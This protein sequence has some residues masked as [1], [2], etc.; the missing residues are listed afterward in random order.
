MNFKVFGFHE[1]L[2]KLFATISVVSITFGCVA[3]YLLLKRYNAGKVSPE[4]F[5]ENFLI[6]FQDSSFILSVVYALF[7]FIVG[8]YLT[9]MSTKLQNLYYR[10]KEQ[11]KNLIRLNEVLSAEKVTDIS[12]DKIMS[13]IIIHQSFTGRNIEKKRKP[14]ILQDGFSYSSKFLELEES[15]LLQ[16]RTIVEIYNLKVNK[17][18]DCYGL[19]KK[20][21]NIFISDLDKFLVEVDNWIDNNLEVAETQ[22]TSFK[23]YLG[24][25][26]QA[27]SRDRRKHK[28]SKVKYKKIILKSKRKVNGLISKIESVYGARLQNDLMFEDNLTFNLF[29][30][31]NIIKA[32]DNKILTY[33]D[34]QELFSEQNSELHEV[35]N[36]IN[37]RIYELKKLFEDD[38]GF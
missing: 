22:R 8:L 20:H 5:F 18:I 9:S 17:Y 6:E 11:Y 3:Y 16:R 15:I 35:I 30:L 33:D 1:R 19:S 36:S 12:D 29:E 34:L 37:D 13:S 31:E 4:N 26:I 21:L 7:L 24:K 38:D 14:Y 10:R 27:S 2:H 28:K 23:N 32:L 25:V